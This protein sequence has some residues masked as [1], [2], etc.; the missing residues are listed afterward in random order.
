MP[1]SSVL[2]QAKALSKFAESILKGAGVSEPKARLI[3]TS[4]V[5]ANLR[6]VDSHGVQLLPFYIERLETG[7]IE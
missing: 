6:G 4:L 5:A 7:D 2:I 3:A 1:N